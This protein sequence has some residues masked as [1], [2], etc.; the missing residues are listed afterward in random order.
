MHAPLA[1]S[2][3]EACT[4]ASIGRSALYEAIRSG[5]LR[6]VKYGRRTLVLARDLNAWIDQLPPIIET[7]RSR[8]Q[9]ANPQRGSK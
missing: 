1:Y 5:E 9:K 4:V 7:D 3:P 2:V 6:A 8:Q